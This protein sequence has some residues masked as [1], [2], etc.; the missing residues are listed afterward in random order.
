[1]RGIAI[2]FIVLHNLLHILLPTIENEFVFNIERSNTFAKVASG[3]S[4]TL[5]QDIFSFLGWYGVTVF[6][7]LSGYG[8]TLKYG[9]STDQP[10]KAKTFVWKHLKR[11]FL[12]MILPYILFAIKDLQD[13]HYLQVFLQLTLLSNIFNPNDIYP[14][15]FWFFGLIAQLYL[16]FAIIRNLRNKDSRSIV[17]VSISALSIILMFFIPGDSETMNHIRHNF[18]GWLLP[19]SMGVWFAGQQTLNKLF[20]SYWK[21]TIW[22]IVCGSLVVI[23]NFNYYMWCISPVFAIMAS[24]GLTKILTRYNK[25]DKGCIWLGA[26]SSFLF[27]VHPTARI[28]YIEYFGKGTPH[29]LNI[30]GYVLVSIA[31]ALIYRAIHKRFFSN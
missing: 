15:I 29:T 30:W 7:F 11:V 1:M 22:V 13:A 23:S 28:L 31:L 27:A 24:I 6:L 18:I 9:F 5:W 12:L 21:N 26:L 14:G 17:L 4:P 2:A 20:D 16:L 19:F 3:F 25:I 10:F 8:L